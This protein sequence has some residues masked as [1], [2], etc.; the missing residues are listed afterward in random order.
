MIIYVCIIWNTVCNQLNRLTCNVP[1]LVHY[2]FCT[3]SSLA[4]SALPENMDAEGHHGL[5]IR[6]TGSVEDCGSLKLHQ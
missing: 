1:P 3:F 6:Y 2:S 5:A 4:D